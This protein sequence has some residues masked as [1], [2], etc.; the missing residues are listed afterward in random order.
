MPPQPQEQTGQQ[1]YL[2]Q[3]R[4]VIDTAIKYPFKRN[5]EEALA[6]IASQPKAYA[7][8]HVQHNLGKRRKEW[9]TTHRNHTV[10]ITDREVNP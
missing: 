3:L 6:L 1:V 4:Y 5:I 7:S 9:I 10:V 2:L 8:S